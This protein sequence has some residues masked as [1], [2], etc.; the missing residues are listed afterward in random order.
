MNK[1]TLI[2][3]FIGTGLSMRAVN[4]LERHKGVTTIEGLVNLTERE[5]RKTKNLGP[6]TCKEIIEWLTK[7]ELSL[8]AHKC[9][10]CK[11]MVNG[12]Q[13]RKT[14]Q[15]ID[16]PKCKT[17]IHV[18]GIERGEKGKEWI[19][20]HCTYN[21]PTIIY[22]GGE[23]EYSNKSMYPWT[24]TSCRHHQDHPKYAKFLLSKNEQD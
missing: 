2:I 10:N 23:H 12:Q 3:E 15:I 4:A 21:P 1:E 20:Y 17:C 19:E 24:Y 7:H 6:N 13:K 11:S 16:R 9:P 5:L 14:I 22:C 18:Y 8:A